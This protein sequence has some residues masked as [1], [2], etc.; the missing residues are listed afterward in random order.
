MEQTMTKAIIYILLFITPVLGAS[1]DGQKNSRAKS[2][3]ENG[4]YEYADVIPHYKGWSQELDKFFQTN[5][6][7]KYIPSPNEGHECVYVKFIVETDSTVSNVEVLKA[8]KKK[9]ADEVVRV[10]KSLKLI[11]AKENGQNVRFRLIWSIGLD[12][13]KKQTK[14]PY[15]STNDSSVLEIVDKMPQ[16]PGGDESF[17]LF[18]ENNA[19]LPENIHKDP[20]YNAVYVK[21][22]IEKDGS[23]SKVSV[24]KTSDENLNEEAVRLTK[25][26]KF[27]PGIEMGKPARV[28]VSFPIVFTLPKPDYEEDVFEIVEKMPEYSGGDPARLAFISE[29]LVYPESAKKMGKEG[30]I[31]VQFIV[32]KDGSV[33]TVKAVKKFDDA[34]A[35]ET[36]RITKLMKWTPA[37]QRNKPVR[38]KIS[39]AVKFKLK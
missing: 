1:Q 20:R 33:S 7:Y 10:V 24:L 12:I 36:I 2:Y 32:E 16:Y 39:M 28:V 29:H 19:S 17:K 9:Y 4:V 3:P 23:T 31:V 13:P 8:S 35:E 22:I 14:K 38:C 11:P 25:L 5:L 6:K 15:S 18:I 27:T 37:M 34:C 21:C 26:M 30:T